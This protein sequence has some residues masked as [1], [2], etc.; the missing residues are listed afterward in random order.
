MNTEY[1]YGVTEHGTKVHIVDIDT[2]SM[3]ARGNGDPDKARCGHTADFTEYDNP[4]L[5]GLCQNCV[6]RHG[7]PDDYRE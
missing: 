4:P 5:T 2:S 1:G 7:I 6:D 3:L